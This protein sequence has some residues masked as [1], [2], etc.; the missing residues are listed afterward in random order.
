VPAIQQGHA[1]R[2]GGELVVLGSEHLEPCLA[3]DQRCLNGLWTAKQWEQELKAAD[4]PCLGLQVGEELV[5]IAC[6]WLVVDELH[7]TAIAV[8][9]NHRRLG[10]GRLLLLGLLQEG[11]QRGAAQA[12]LEVSSSNQAAR[13]L[14]EGGG[15]RTSGCR[16]GYYRTGDDALIQW[17]CFRDSEGV[18][19]AA[20]F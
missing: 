9:P 7:I 6:G 17:M 16:R 5:G 12:T 18:R 3:L 1:P 15:F 8:D 20:L 14:Y 19:I 2:P 10:L 11:L 4:R 13:R